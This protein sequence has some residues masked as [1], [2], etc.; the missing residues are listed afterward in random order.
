LN[1]P[2]SVAYVFPG[3][4]AQWVGMGKDLYQQY[5]PAMELFDLADA[6]L[7]FSLSRLC[8][9]GPEDDLRQTENAQPAI[10]AV[11]L[12]T[13]AALKEKKWALPQPAYV[14]GHSLG[15]YTA[16]AAAGV[17]DAAS[18]I[19]LAWERGR[20]MQQAGQI[21]PGGMAA[22]IG[23]SQH[24]VADLC[25]ETGTQIANINCP[26]QL[27]IS[28]AAD[29]L[30][31]AIEL[32]RE[33]GAHRVV[34]LVVSGAFHTPLMQ[35]AVDGMAEVI[36]SLKFNPPQVPIIANTSAQPLTTATD[37]KEELLRQ[38]TNS[39]RWQASVE[40]MISNGV[41][42]FIEIGPGR[43][44]SGLIRRTSKT[45]HTVNLGDARAI[46]EFGMQREAL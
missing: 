40:Y 23:L 35:P 3:Q 33:R 18:T 25:A 24:Q 42:T 16:L 45:A 12:A 2:P 17:L 8:F 26:G 37:V 46:N 19:R 22:V 1:K 9:E 14:A 41:D 38:L 30:A 10:V 15:E 13:L 7:R 21:N 29:K 43:V 36:T 5:A 20:L 11:S 39:V 34:P 28:G 27:V 44:L 4:G 6:T 31:R 32:A